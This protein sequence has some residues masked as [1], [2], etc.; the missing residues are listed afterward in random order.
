[1]RGLCGV[2]IGCDIH[3]GLD[4]GICVPW[5]VQVMIGPGLIDVLYVPVKAWSTATCTAVD[6]V[7]RLD[8]LDA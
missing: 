1:M 5:G 7:R 3:A 4:T 2:M 6:V 8:C